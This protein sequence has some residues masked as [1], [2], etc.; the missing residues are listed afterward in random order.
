MAIRG[1]YSLHHDT[2]EGAADLSPLQAPTSVAPMVSMSG[3]PTT[4]FTMSR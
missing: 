4:G 3:V 1:M 2:S